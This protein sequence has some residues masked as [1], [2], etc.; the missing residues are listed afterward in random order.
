MHCYCMSCNQALKLFKIIRDNNISGVVLLGH[1][2][3]RAWS[4]F[5][6]CHNREAGDWNINILKANERIMALKTMYS[7]PSMIVSP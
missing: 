3:G 5:A 1:L 4:H 7:K 6:A 2:V